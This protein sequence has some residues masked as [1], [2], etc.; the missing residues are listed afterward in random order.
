MKI[1][2]CSI[3]AQ[4]GTCACMN[5]ILLI[6]F[7]QGNSFSLHSLNGLAVHQLLMLQIRV[8]T[9]VRILPVVLSMPC[10]KALPNPSSSFHT[11]RMFVLH[12][13]ELHY[14]NVFVCQHWAWHC[15]QC[16]LTKS[17]PALSPWIMDWLVILRSL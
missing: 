17:R 8:V 12:V 9:T 13:C 1:R 16:M 7:V 11:C 3:S 10:T 2:T 4:K 5:I 6:K 15:L 14:L